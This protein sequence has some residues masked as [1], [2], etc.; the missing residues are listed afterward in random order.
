MGKKL[1]SW[2]TKGMNRDLGVSAFSPEFSFENRNL[3]LSTNEFNTLLSW[4]NEKG[5]ALLPL[6]TYTAPSTYTPTQLNGVPIGTAIVNSQLVVFTTEAA[7]DG[8]PQRDR[9]YLLTYKDVNKDVMVCKML[10]GTN[11]I[12]LNFDV[13][14]PL[15]TLVNY[16]TESIQKVYW[17]DGINQPRMINIVGEINQSDVTQFD[18]VP[19][20]TLQEE[21]TVEKILGGNGMFAPGVIQ[22]AFTYYRKNG[23]ESNIFYTTPLYYISHKDRGASPEDKVENAFKIKVENPDI[24]FDY[25]RIYSIQRTSIN[26]IPIVKRIQDLSLEDFDSD[27]KKYQTTYVHSTTAPIVMINGSASADGQFHTYF[28]VE[29]VRVQCTGWIKSSTNTLVVN[30]SDNRVYYGPNAS[31]NSTIWVT[32]NT[33]PKGGQNVYVVFETSGPSSSAPVE[34]VTTL[35]LS[36]TYLSYID[37]GLNG[38][39]VD[40][41]EM[42][43]KGGEIVTAQTIEQKDNTLFLGN[44]SVVRNNLRDKSAEI[45]SSITISSSKRYFN[46]TLITT[47]NYHYANQLTSYK[48]EGGST[49]VSVPCGGFKTGD[50]YRL[51][52]QF[53]H[54]SGKWTEPFYIGD[55]EETEKPSYNTTNN[56]VGVPTFSGQFGAGEAGQQLLQYLTSDAVGYVKIRPVVVFPKM[57]D[58]TVICQG[59]T[60]PVMWRESEQQRQSSWFFRPSVDDASEGVLTT[61]MAPKSSGYLEY[62]SRQINTTQPKLGTTFNPSKIRQVEIEGEFSNN[63]TDGYNKFQIDRSYRTFHS[64]DIEFDEQ[65][66]LVDFSGKSYRQIGSAVFEY[67]MSDIDIQTES[68]T[69]SNSGGGFVHKSFSSSGAR[70]IVSGLFYDDFIV[71]DD[72]GDGTN[73]LGAYPYWYQ[74]AKW[75]IY[76]WQG[77]GSLNNDMN[78]PADKGTITAK[79][80]KKIISNLRY[81]TTNQLSGTQTNNTFT[82]APQLFASDQ[83]TI[84]KVNNNI[85]KGNV[86]TVLVPDES[87]GVYYAFDGWANNSWANQKTAFTSTNWWKTF[88]L[89]PT[90]SNQNGQ[91]RWNHSS[92]WRCIDGGNVGDKYV[93][94]VMKKLPVRMKYKSTAHLFGYFPSLSESTNELAIVEIRQNPGESVRFGGTSNDALKENT[95]ISCGEPVRLDN[96][97]LVDDDAVVTIKYSYGDTYY[98]RWDCLKTYPYTR[99]DL[100][101]IVE[102]GSFMLETRANI[103]GRYDRNRGQLNNLNMSPTNFNLMNPIYTQVDN[104]FSYKIMDEDYYDDTTY[105]NQITWSKTKSSGADVDLW[106]NITMASVLELD[107][108]KGALNKI[109][110]FNDQLLAFQDTGI[111]QILYNENTQIT[112]T[113]GV[114]IEIANSGKVTGKRYISTTVG[115]S[116]KWSMVA[117]PTGIY[118]MDSNDKSIYTF[119]GQLNN[120]STSGGFNTYCKYCIPPSSRTW[121]P[122]FPVV[123]LQTYNFSAFVAYYDK[124]NQDVLFINN[125]TALAYSEKLSAF[126]SFYDYGGAGYFCNLEDTGVWIKTNTLWKHQAGDYCRFFGINKPYSMI[127]IA[128]LEPQLTKTFTNLEFRAS[129]DNDMWYDETTQKYYPYLPFDSI[130]VWDEYQHGIGYLKD[131]RDVRPFSHHQ[132][133]NQANINRKFRIWRTDIPRDNADNADVFDETFDRTFHILARIQKHPQDRMRNPWLYFRLRKAAAIDELVEGET[134]YHSLNRMELQDIVMTYFD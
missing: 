38:D 118:F 44:L 91:Y 116:N 40:P 54:K 29:G 34:Q 108:D 57:M 80:K 70:G 23:Q 106:T 66:S 95:W 74:S 61:T 101:Q 8:Q 94:L 82:Y 122:T 51:G 113:D 84:L 107:G 35:N 47:G 125:Q 67:T 2:K 100:N 46:P 37:T 77:S 68:P 134:V 55:F 69:V 78:R 20:L 79:L 117:T 126:T 93:D 98:Q 1:M 25:L 65:L 9:I 120:L 11:N 27:G 6:M 92:E 43:Y 41:T 121:N 132:L 32:N 90:E 10:F 133:D 21:I 3:R 114:P 24:H 33:I 128:N 62:T 58:R 15:E 49:N 124:V 59:V 85:Y 81:S 45:Q 71:D 26:A 14:H 127:M 13:N 119:N 72:L 4:V 109:I 83:E 111:S 56:L 48:N 18:F 7:V 52:V 103:D 123:D 63:S 31:T 105:L 97:T 89:S 5:T 130:E 96:T 42:L 75:L 30:T 87:D 76:P 110:R 86:D 129:V 64:P 50:Y 36:D 102:I 12:S 88:S 131:G 99:E 115:C 22:Y 112:T 73:D 19:A 17:T 104:F 60:N 16:E 53:Q 39:S 28:V